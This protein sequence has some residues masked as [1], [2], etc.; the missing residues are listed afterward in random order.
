MNSNNQ[1]ER[2]AMMPWVEAR[3]IRP[4]D[5]L[6]VLVDGRGDVGN[7]ELEFKAG[8][9]VTVASAENFRGIQGWAITIVASNG[10][11]NVFDE[12]DFS[13]RYPFQWISRLS[14]P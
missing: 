3:R 12:A 14:R 10:V 13:G 9:I 4:G 8:E 6:R 1:A 5:K 11:V 7:D 2:A